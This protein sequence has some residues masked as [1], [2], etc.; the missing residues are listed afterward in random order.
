M[1]NA[2]QGAL[3]ASTVKTR[4]SGTKCPSYWVWCEIQ[5][6]EFTHNAIPPH[7]SEIAECFH[8]GNHL[9]TC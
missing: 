7:V 2:L 9:P 5:W 8:E 6:Q 4:I 1:L 3:S